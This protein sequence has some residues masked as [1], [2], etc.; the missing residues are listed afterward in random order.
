MFGL[1]G[2]YIWKLERQN[3]TIN[4]NIYES[5]TIPND[6]KHLEKEETYRTDFETNGEFRGF[7]KVVAASFEKAK[8]L[9]DER[10]K[11]DWQIL[12]RRPWAPL[13]NQELLK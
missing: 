2:T 10:K 9:D 12:W 3:E 1:S 7:V 6:R 8:K 5:Q 11:A 4:I 13:P